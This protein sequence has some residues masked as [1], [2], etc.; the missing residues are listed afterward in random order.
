[1][2][3]DKFTNEKFSQPAF[4]IISTALCV[5]K[6]GLKPKLERATWSEIGELTVNGPNRNMT[7]K[8]HYASGTGIFCEGGSCE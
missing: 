3:L 2:I 4:S 6:E 1:M 7:N 8:G 5:I